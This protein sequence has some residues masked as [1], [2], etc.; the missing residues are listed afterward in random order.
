VKLSSKQIQ[1]P[2][3]PNELE[4]F[5]KSFCNADDLI[6]N[7]TKERFSKYLQDE[8]FNRKFINFTY[9][10]EENTPYKLLNSAKNDKEKNIKP[11]S[12]TP[13]IQNNIENN[14]TK[15]KEFTHIIKVK[16]VQSSKERSFSIKAIRDNRLLHQLNNFHIKEDKSE[17]YIMKIKNLPKL[18]DRNQVKDIK[19][20]VKLLS[21]ASTNANDLFS[22]RILS[23]VGN[24]SNIG[25]SVIIEKKI[26]VSNISNVLNVSK[27]GKVVF[28]DEIFNKNFEKDRII[29]KRDKKSEK[30]IVAT[31]KKS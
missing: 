22:Q 29:L 5:D 13:L 12:Y 19:K 27:V 21:Q 25:N 24:V 26:S 23:N 7:S 30:G 3:I 2:F 14:I 31:P 8:A 6:G 15:I 20:K 9:C 18:L 1:S 17:A 16:D 10:K 4:N 28:K 11:N